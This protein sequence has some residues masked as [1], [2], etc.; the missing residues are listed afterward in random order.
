M[1]IFKSF[2]NQ[3][4]LNKQSIDQGKPVIIPFDFPKLSKFIPGVI[5]GEQILITASS[6]VGKSRFTRKVFIKD[7]L[8]YANRHNMPIKIFLNSLEESKEKVASTLVSETLY[9]KYNITLDYYTLNNYRESSLSE[10]IMSK[11]GECTDIA[12]EVYRQLE[13]VNIPSATGF[14]KH[15][16][17]YLANTGRFLYK[18]ETVSLGDRWDAYA[19]NDPNM[20]VIAISDTIDKY[21]AENILGVPQSQY[22]TLKFFSSTY[23]RQRLGLGCGVINV[24]VQQQVNDK[25]IIETNYKGNTVV[26]KMKPSLATLAKCKL[27]QEDATLAF[28]LFDPLRAGVTEYGG[29]DLENITYS[30]RSWSILKSRESSLEDREIALACNF[31]IDEFKEL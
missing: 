14:Y 19:P 28:G 10:E 15:V 12:E 26:E 7:M 22:E 17:G 21:P 24:L 30:F 5:R 23:S 6:G 11:I 20:I 29:I 4:R 25:E 9:R 1:S 3:S 31:V 8:K 2:F 27:T 18:G 13:V 16:R